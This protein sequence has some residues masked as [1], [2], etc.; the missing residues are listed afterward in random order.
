MA[1]SVAL[2]EVSFAPACLSSSSSSPSSSSDD[3]DVFSVITSQHAAV[4]SSISSPNNR[5]DAPTFTVAPNGISGSKS[6][7]EVLE[8][9]DFLLALVVLRPLGLLDPLLGGALV[10]VAVAA[11]EVVAVVLLF[12]EDEPLKLLLLVFVAAAIISGTGCC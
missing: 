11:A 7:T 12:E 2:A 4:W 5:G 10:F 9:P 6:K 1:A 3:D 8:L